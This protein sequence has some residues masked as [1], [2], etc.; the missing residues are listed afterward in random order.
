MIGSVPIAIIE[1]LRRVIRPLT[2]GMR[3]CAN[4]MGGHLIFD[5]LGVFNRGVIS[6]LCIRFYEVFVCIIQGIIFSLLVLR[7]RAE[8]EERL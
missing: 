3:L 2:L 7:Y 4:I 8:S 6:Y 1:F 5:L